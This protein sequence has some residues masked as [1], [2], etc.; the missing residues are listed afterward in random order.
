[1]NPTGTSQSVN[2]II[3]LDT[4]YTTV[5]QCERGFPLVYSR[6][7]SIP[8]D[9]KWRLVVLG[10]IGGIGVILYLITLILFFIRIKKQPL[11]DRSPYLLMVSAVAGSLGLAYMYFRQFFDIVLVCPISYYIMMISLFVYFVPYLLRC[12][13]TIMLWNFNIAKASMIENGDIETVPSPSSG[14]PS[15]PTSS[16]SSQPLVRNR[17]IV[18][19]KK[20]A[21]L[22]RYRRF[23]SEWFLLLL[24]LIGTVI[25]TLGG[26]IIQVVSA[27]KGNFWNPNCQKACN[28]Q[29]GFAL[30]AF[31]VFVAVL[32]FPYL[33]LG[34][35]MRNIN[36]EFSIRNE[37]ITI[38]AFS[39][40]MLVGMIVLVIIPNQFWPQSSTIGYLL[41]VTLIGTHLISVV[42]PLVNTW[43][44]GGIFNAIFR[45]ITKTA[46]RGKEEEASATP[47]TENGPDLN[48]FEHYLTDKR[49]REVF[50][51]FLVREFSVENL[52]F[53]TEVKFLKN[54]EEQ[55]EIVETANSINTTYVE[56]GAPFEINILSDVRNKI[57]QELGTQPS[58]NTF[59]EAQEAVLQI[60]KEE[61]FPRFK[62]HVLYSDYVKEIAQ[63]K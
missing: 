7:H 39:S 53:H 58:K 61:S 8:D 60:M 3:P 50:K 24:L 46:G 32:E 26:M 21:P 11:R 40:L 18:N 59:D 43:V 44:D 36:D 33:A 20:H 2:S 27:T 28:Q 31:I 56:V 45:L 5:S 63:A 52:M 37:L 49:G 6:L 12:V 14:S 1:M 47:T 19:T 51:Q 4:M 15:S 13:R 35:Y 41:G 25:W 55:S 38:I 62:K 17:T 54:I 16:P 22:I 10:I 29:E 57:A 9:G 42:Y 48:S 23:F 30:R 34:I